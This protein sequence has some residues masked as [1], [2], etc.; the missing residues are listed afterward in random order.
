MV[1]GGRFVTSLTASQRDPLS[2]GGLGKSANCRA[3]NHD[4]VAEA[5]TIGARADPEAANWNPYRSSHA[6]ASCAII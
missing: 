3:V 6:T 5:T 4:T 1:A 2:R